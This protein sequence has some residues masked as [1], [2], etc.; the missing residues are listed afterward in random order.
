MNEKVEEKSSQ[1]ISLTRKEMLNY[2]VGYIPNTFMA[3]VFTLLYVN[4]F[5]NYLELD[6]GFFVIGQIIYATINALNDP[7]TGHISDKT[8][9]DRWGSRRLIYI[10]YFGPL[11]A[12]FYFLM[13]IP[14]SFDSQIIIFIHFVLSICIFDTFLSL[15]I[16]L[17]MSLMS[18]IT[19]SVKFRYRLFFYANIFSFIGLIPAI[20][21][22]SFFE[23]SLQMFQIFNGIFAVLC[24]ILYI[25]AVR[26]INE[27]PELRKEEDYSFFQAMKAVLKSR[28]FLSRTAY[29]F[30]NNIGRAMVYSFVF[31][32]LYILGEGPLNQ[33]LFIAMVYMVGF[34]SQYIYMIVE[35]RWG[36]RKTIL[37]LKSTYVILSL[38]SFLIVVIFDAPIFVWICVAV[39]SL[40]SGFNVFDFVLLTFA[41]DEDELKYGSRRESIFQ[42]TSSLLFKPADSLGPIIATQILLAFSF[43]QG[44]P[45]QT[46]TALLG[47]KVLLF[48]A[49]AIFHAISLIF[50]YL[51]PYYGEKLEKLNKE[52]KALHAQKKQKY[53]DRNKG[54]NIQEP[55]N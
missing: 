18:E 44:E 51:F 22:Q 49:P 30:F 12:V 7:V 43:I 27:R 33:I 3:G 25:Y 17:Y 38:I 24:I 19:D 10:K 2:A 1:Y 35:N 29:I 42:G 6:Q 15:V 46:P 13:W 20:F 45:V 28:A 50:I 4:F 37:V 21:A 8:D 55:I 48:V 32:F 23:S 41:I 47:I 53:T 9:V 31:A 39:I 54:R 36:I 52:I 16:G 5:W 11:W 14:W 26:H 40:F 34:V